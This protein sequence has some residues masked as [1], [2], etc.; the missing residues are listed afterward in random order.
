MGDAL[1][2]RLNPGCPLP[3][4][5]PAR[6]ITFT[7]AGCLVGMRLTLPVLPGLL[8]FAIAFGTASAQRGLTLG[9]SVAMSMFVSGGASQ[10]LSIELW[11]D[12]WSIGAV[13]TITLVTA[14][15]NARFMLQGA[16]LQPWMKGAPV[17]A[18]AA[19]L[20]VLFESS[21]MVAERHRAEGG[22]DLGVM[23]GSGVLSWAVWFTS[24]VPGY[25]AGT[26]VSDPRR[27]ALDLV[28]PFFFAAMAVPLWRGVAVSALPWAVA[29][30]V[31]LG[32]QAI[33]PG[34]L[35]I[36]A[37]ALAGALTGALSRGRR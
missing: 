24:T 23:F 3:A 20:F 31:A 5:A 22:R 26:L 19:T 10:M 33:L 16:S 25:L 27:Y 32:V 1:P 21:W 18:Q 17:M 8:A 30:A 11:R 14:T 37:G 13:A 9:E 29:A 4:P 2:R 34:Y 6:P 7:L 12:A 15:V 35:F 28:L 36:V